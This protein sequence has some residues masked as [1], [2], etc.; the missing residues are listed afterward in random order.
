MGVIC[1]IGKIGFGKTLNMTLEAS[2][3]FKRENRK[4]KIWYTEKIKKQEYIYKINQY[5]TYPIIF[6][7]SKDSSKR[8]KYYKYIDS[9]DPTKNV[10]EETKNN[11]LESFKLRIYDMNIR[12]NF[13]EKSSFYIDDIN[14]FY[15]SMDYKDFPDKIAQFF[16]IHRHLE[17]NDIYTNSQSISRIIKRVLVLSEE[18]WKI[19]KVWK[20]F[21]I[22]V[23][24]YEIFFDTA[25]IKE[26]ETKV[27]YQESNKAIKIFFLKKLYKKYDTKYL[28]A[29]REH[30]IPYDNVMWEDKIL[31]YEDLDHMRT[32]TEEELKFLNN[33]RNKIKKGNR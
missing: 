7:E 25:Q 32:P 13:N 14:Q 3:K 23:T 12:Y 26:D 24:F 19:T 15:D 11:R 18:F 2:R 6:L 17:Y 10:I 28:R 27:S 9:L 33:D 16:Q 20:L 31:H 1:I 21:F 5:S 8:F 4:I 30:G 29:Y 22:G